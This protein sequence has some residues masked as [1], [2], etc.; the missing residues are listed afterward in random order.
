MVPVVYG[1]HV[2]DVRAV[3]EEFNSPGELAYLNY[4][5]SKG[6]AYLEHHQIDDSSMA[7][8]LLHQASGTALANLTNGS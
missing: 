6:M 7:N 3:A 5:D 8:I 4:F 2:D 1:P